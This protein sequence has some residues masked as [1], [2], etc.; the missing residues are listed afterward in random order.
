MYHSQYYKESQEEVKNSCTSFNLLWGI[1]SG[2]FCFIIL[3]I[4]VIS[5]C[6]D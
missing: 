1:L 3:A 5:V 4:K 6:V 2:V